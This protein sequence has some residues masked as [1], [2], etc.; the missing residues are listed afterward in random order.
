MNWRSMKQL[1]WLVLAGSVALLAP[2]ARG[3]DF[4]NTGQL[5]NNGRF[6]VKRTV[7][8]LP[9]TVGGTFEYNGAAQ[10]VPAA[11]YTNLRLTGT[12]A[13]NTAGGDFSVNG[14]LEIAPAVTLTVQSGAVITLGDSLIEQ[15]YL[16]GGIQNAQTIGTSAPASFGNI[17]PVL[18]PNGV[19]LGLTNVKR[20]SGEA[21]TAPNGKSSIKR[22]YDITA[23]NNTNLNASLVFT[24]ADNELN[25]HDVRSLELWRFDTADSTWRRQ[26]GTVDTAKRTVTKN[27]IV[28]F[29]RWT[30]ADTASLLGLP[31]YEWSPYVVAE[32]AGNTQLVKAR[33]ESRPVTAR[34]TDAYRNPLKGYP[35]VFSFRSAPSGATGQA[36]TKDT[37]LTDS[38]GEATTRLIAGNKP[39]V[40][41][42]QA[43]AA[44]LSPQFFTATAAIVSGDAN[45][46]FASDVADLTSIVAHIRG[47]IPLTGDK[48]AFADINGDGRVD[49]KDIDSIRTNILNGTDVLDSTGI[50]P[51][52]SLDQSAR[53]ST[54]FAP[55]AVDSI[56]AVVGIELTK[57]GI[58]VN[59]KNTVA[60]VGLQVYVRFKDPQS[61]N[62]TDVV[63]PRSKAMDIRMK[64]IG[65]ELRLVGYNLSNTPITADSGS[66]FRLPL[67]LASVAD[68]ESV[69]V[70]V[71][72]DSNKAVQPFVRTTLA[73]VTAYPSSFA[74]YQNYPNPFN[75]S[76][77]I[78]YD[79]PDVPGK[80]KIAYLFVY[81]ILGRR[82]RTLASGEHEAKRHSVVWDG[83]DENGVTVGSGVYF[84][85]L[86]GK[87]FVSSKKMVYIK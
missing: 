46:D 75:G 14:F 27:G 49:V 1:R 30:A 87:D 23:A 44:G 58:R 66:L 6:V 62:S 57:T 68:I 41:Q 86:I 38:L 2:L 55:H 82:V 39:G 59:M 20:T 56:V 22:Y 7:S 76:T 84:Y 69:S 78:E 16:S 29:S 15:G 61:L 51:T 81:D 47:T 64:T 83:R 80:L 67:N 54:L 77:V 63:Y 43:A 74:I 50:I 18:A 13:K 48:L 36:F 12:S 9:T 60:I 24:F 52:Q 33:T 32:R 17:G 21:L 79:V 25:G 31:Q 65:R 11:T 42:F 26:G 34:L 72:T 70:V 3:Q 10:T 19:P 85:Q 73:P 53:S 35:I 37:V 8:G 28:R 5:N 4:V 40:Y 71:S 45:N